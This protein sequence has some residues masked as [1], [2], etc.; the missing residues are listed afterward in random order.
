MQDYLEFLEKKKTE[1][2]DS[3]FQ[4]SDNELNASL[5]DFQRHIVKTALKKGKY[6][7]FADCGLGKT[8]MQLEWANQVS[9]H[10]NK[11]VL[12]LA[13]LAVS[14]QTIN[15][16]KK[17]GIEVNKWTNDYIEGFSGIYITNYEQL[18]NVNNDLS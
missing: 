16:G 3:G 15:E 18:E 17:F 8:L 9:K 6:A 5:F 10:E 12:I 11:P 2:S 13:P 14:G 1:H 4:I 7:I